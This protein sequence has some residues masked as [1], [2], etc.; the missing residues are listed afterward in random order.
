[1]GEGG[2]L[3]RWWDRLTGRPGTGASRHDPQA[4]LASGNSAP[5]KARTTTVSSKPADDLQLA[6]D[7]AGGI[8]QRGRVGAGGFDPY[9][10]DAG[11]EKPHSWERI[12][13]D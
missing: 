7:K 9:S 1:M 11:F 10:S 8:R 13:R 6:D 2:F 5:G 3:R 12:D 4:R